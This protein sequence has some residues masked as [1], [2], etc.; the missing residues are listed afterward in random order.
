MCVGVFDVG[1]FVVVIVNVIEL[2]DCVVSCDVIM[3]DSEDMLLAE[4]ALAAASVVVVAAATTAKKQRKMWVRP[5][6]RRRRELGVYDAVLRGLGTDDPQRYAAFLRMSPD[7]FKVLLQIVE[8]DISGSSQ[9]RLPIPADVRL[10]V[11]LRYMATGWLHST[12]LQIKV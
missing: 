8:R 10:A 2:L 4:A 12:T 6:L 7:D 1:F 9:Y 11:T 3:A 5:Y